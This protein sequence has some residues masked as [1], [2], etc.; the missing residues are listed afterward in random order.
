M[1]IAYFTHAAR[2]ILRAIVIELHVEFRDR[3]QTLIDRAQK[4]DGNFHDRWGQNGDAFTFHLAAIQEAHSMRMYAN[5]II[6]S[7]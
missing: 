3:L 6:Y 4:Q 1:R 7:C 5:T 2:M